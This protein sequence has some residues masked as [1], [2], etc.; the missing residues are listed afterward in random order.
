MSRVFNFEVYVHFQTSILVVVFY[1][2]LLPLILNISF[3][4]LCNVCPAERTKELL[5]LCLA[6]PQN[7]QL[8]SFCELPFLLAYFW[9]CCYQPNLSNIW[10]LLWLH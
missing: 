3:Q 7:P 8:Y 9:R 4:C 6:P 2:L 1:L 10:L 5:S